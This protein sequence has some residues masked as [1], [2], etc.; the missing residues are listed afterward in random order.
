V[1]NS[2]RGSISLLAATLIPPLVLLLGL[3]IQHSFHIALEIKTHCQRYHLQQQSK[4]N[5]GF[6][7][8]E[9]VGWISVLML[10]A[11]ALV[12]NQKEVDQRIKWALLNCQ[13]SFTQATATNK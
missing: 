3:V 9:L 2:E 8:L 13:N 1:K 10:L 4:P 6:A 7:A 12:Q 11:Y 5:R